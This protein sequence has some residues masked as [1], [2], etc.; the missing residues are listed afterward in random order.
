MSWASLPD[1]T[2]GRLER[3]LELA[4][5]GVGGE[6]E[7]A[8]AMLLRLLD[9]N[10]LT[11]ADLEAISAPEWHEFD[12]VGHQFKDLLYQLATHVLDT[13]DTQIRRHS[14]P[15]VTMAIIMC[16]HAQATEIRVAFSV[17]QPALAREFDAALTA[18]I[19]VNELYSSQAD[20]AA[21]RE[22]RA[23]SEDEIENIRRALE[24]ANGMRPTPVHHQ[25]EGPKS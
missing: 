22:A 19:H 13:R 1:A 17:Y 6:A 8:Q 3:L 12:F 5:R 11:M 21:E 14:D 9:A 2:R 24:I 7:T 4:R 20:A 23:L 16:T 18:F 10:G 15:G 25:L